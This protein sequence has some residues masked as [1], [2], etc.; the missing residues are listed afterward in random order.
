MKRLL[1]GIVL[2]VSVALPVTGASDPPQN[3]AV[4]PRVD[5]EEAEVIRTVVTRCVAEAREFWREVEEKQEQ[6]ML[7]PGAA[8]HRPRSILADRTGTPL[9]GYGFV[10]NVDRPAN[11]RALAKIRRSSAFALFR[12]RSREGR[13][14][15]PLA[16]T[17]GVTLRPLSEIPSD[18]SRS[19]G[20]GVT[21]IDLVVPEAFYKR[22]P[23]AASLIIVSRPAID[24]DEAVVHVSHMVVFGIEGRIF[25]LRRHGFQ[26]TIETVAIVEDTPGC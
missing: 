13:S 2:A 15:A 25:R 4:L 12:E 1:Q 5:S 8:T 14:L 24:G 18:P 17:E 6:T 22:Y 10:Y 11:D 26:W 16:D 3:P 21:E 19:R 7:G 23:D 9:T 20:K